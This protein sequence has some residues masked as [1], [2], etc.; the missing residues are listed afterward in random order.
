MD[1]DW[2]NRNRYRWYP[3]LSRLKLA[4]GQ[5]FPPESV[6][7]LGMIMGGLS[8]HR[9]ASHEFQLEQVEPVSTDVKFTFRSTAPELNA[10]D[11]VAQVATD[12]DFGQIVDITCPSGDDYGYGFLVV[13]DLGPLDTALGGSSQAVDAWYGS[14]PATVEPALVQTNADLVVTS[15]DAYEREPT[16]WA[17]PGQS[18]PSPQYELV[19]ESLTGEVDFGDGYNCE[20]EI[21]GTENALLFRAGLDRGEGGLCNWSSTPGEPLCGDLIATINGVQATPEGGFLLNSGI[22]V[23][24]SPHEQSSHALAFGTGNVGDLYCLSSTPGS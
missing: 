11:F 18:T 22:G 4:N 2:Y 20:V 5:E 16:P 1:I 12:A 7:E 21:R 15:I 13:G 19:G 10:V 24:I 9:A 17:P 14:E 6:L 3:F 23:D 8:D